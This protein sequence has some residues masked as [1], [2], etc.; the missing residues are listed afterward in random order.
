LAAGRPARLT[1]AEGRKF[2]LTL[3]A[4][5][6]VLALVAWWRGGARAPIVFGALAALFLLGGALLPTRL[7]PVQRAWMGMAHAIS[8]VTT[9]IFMGVVYFLV[10]TPAGLIRRLFGANALRAAQGRTSGWVDRRDSP[11]GDLTRQF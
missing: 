6:A 10:I 8:K 1:S 9:P 3:A 5:F 7:G 4:A 2:G 11:R